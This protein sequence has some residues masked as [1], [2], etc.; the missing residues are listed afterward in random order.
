MISV[1]EEILWD[2]EEAPPD[3]LWRLQRIADFFPRYGGDRQTVELLY[4]HRNEL[5]LDDATRELIEEYFLA[6]QARES[7]SRS[8]E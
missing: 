8:L 4:R 6:W 7:I 1:P 5:K 3:L 2:Y